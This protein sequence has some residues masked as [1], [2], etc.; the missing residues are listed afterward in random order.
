M[1]ESTIPLNAGSGGRTLRSRQRNISATNVEE[2]YIIPT[3]E[4]VVTYNGNV[5]TFRTPGRAGTSGQKLFAIHNATGSAVLVKVDSLNVS[6][7]DTAAKLVAPPLVRAW[8]F[9]AIPTN[10]TVLSKRGPDTAEASNASVTVWGDA[11][12]DGTASGTALA[13]TLPANQFISQFPAH[14]SLTLV[15]ESTPKEVGLLKFTGTQT[16]RAL[17]GIAVFLDYTV[18][19]SNPITDMWQVDCVWREYTLP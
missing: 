2:Q 7:F 10:G 16:L 9:T 19:T 4:E 15:G 18:A 12:A 3:T 5:G 1:P 11:S 17:Q 14:R 8:R 13:V 6:Y